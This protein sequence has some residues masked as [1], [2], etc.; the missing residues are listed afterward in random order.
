MNETLRKLEELHLMTANQKDWWQGRVDL[1]T[2]D[3]CSDCYWQGV[4]DVLETIEDVQRELN[5]V[6][7]ELRSDLAANEPPMEH[8]SAQPKLL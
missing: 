8:S 7:V 2:G 3:D 1:N 6:I 5:D 4:D